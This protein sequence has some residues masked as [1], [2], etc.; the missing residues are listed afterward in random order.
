MR[1]VRFIGASVCALC[2]GVLFAAE[3]VVSDVTISQAAERDPVTITYRLTG[4]PSII[5]LEILNNGEP[6]AGERVQYVTGDAN[7]LVEPTAE[8]EV[9]TIKWQA[10]KAWPQQQFTDAAIS[11]RVT[12]WTTNAPPNVLVVD[13]SDGAMRYYTDESYLPYGGLT[14]DLYRLSQMV[15]RRI[16]AAGVETTL[17][18]KGNEYAWQQTGAGGREA[19]H[20]VKF[21]KDFYMGVFEVTQGQ[22]SKVYSRNPSSYTN[23]TYTETRPV[24]GVGYSQIRGSATSGISVWTPANNV[25]PSSSSFIGKLRTRTGAAFDLP[26]ECQWEYAAHGGTD[27]MFYNGH[28]YITTPN[29]GDKVDATVLAEAQANLSLLGRWQGN[30]GCLTGST[31]APFDCTTEYGT[32]RVGSYLPSDYGLYDMLGNVREICREPAMLENGNGPRAWSE[33]DY[34]DPV[35]SQAYNVKTLEEIDTSQCGG[36]TLQKGGSWRDPWYVCRPS[37]A[38]ADFYTWEGRSWAGC[39]IILEIPQP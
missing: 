19:P 1:L 2:A 13:L 11:A 39:R 33:T 27:E 30:G 20:K 31:W 21:S 15:F 14:N 38:S 26:T 37:F 9:R 8:G 23:L 34:V 32:A 4:D 28:T 18:G 24:E 35:S 25:A 5:T 16:P 6:V 22:W 10:D 17:G 12:A 29:G 36:A 7:K 3:S